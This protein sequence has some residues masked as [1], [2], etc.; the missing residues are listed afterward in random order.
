MGDTYCTVLGE[1]IARRIEAQLIPR[2]LRRVHRP[3]DVHTVVICPVGAGMSWETAAE[4]EI[5]RLQC[6][7]LSQYSDVPLVPLFGGAGIDPVLARKL[8]MHTVLYHVCTDYSE[9]T[10]EATT[11]DGVVAHIDR[12]YLTDLPPV[13]VDLEAPF[14]DQLRVP[15]DCT[16]DVHLRERPRQ[17]LEGMTWDT[18]DGLPGPGGVYY[19]LWREW[20]ES[21]S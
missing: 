3:S 11:A 7:V 5:W 18:P 16:C 15:T 17:Y 14:I 13:I 9:G 1:E 8:G 4:I 10:P 6:Q 12:L 2:P 19:E 21:S 20:K